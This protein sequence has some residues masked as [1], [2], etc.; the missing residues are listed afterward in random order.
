MCFGYVNSN[1][2]DLFYENL[3]MTKDKMMVGSVK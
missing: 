3:E 2:E 1:F